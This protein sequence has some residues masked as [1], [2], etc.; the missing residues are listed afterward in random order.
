MKLKDKVN[1]YQKAYQ[2][3]NDYPAEALE[4]EMPGQVYF[5]ENNDILCLPRENGD[6]RYPLGQDGFNYWVYAS[7]YM[8]SNEGLFSQYLRASEGQ[9]PKIAF[10]AGFEK[11]GQ[12]E[13][14]PLLSVPV[15]LAKECVE[16][17]TIFTTK[18]AYYIT[19]TNGVRFA[20]RV[21]VDVARNT[22]W[23]LTAENLSHENKKFFVASYFNPFLKNAVMEGAENRWF[24]QA[25]VV[26]KKGEQN[27]DSFLIEVYEERDRGAMM[28]NYAVFTRHI[29]ASQGAE[30][31][32]IEE[33]T[34][35]NDY[36]GGTISSLHTPKALYKGTFGQT[37]KVTSFTEIGI[38][39]DI[40]HLA[41][42]P[43]SDIRI[44]TKMSCVLEEEQKD[45]A[46]SSSP[47]PQMIDALESALI[48]QDKARQEALKVKFGKRLKAEIKEEV[49]NA[50][51][52]H[53]KKQVEF[54]A[55]IKGYVQLSN[56]SLI[57]IRDVYQA[58]EGLIAWQ[59]ETARAKMLEGLN[60]IQPDGRAPRQYSL[61][62][63]EG[64]SPAMDLRAFIDQGVWIISTI[65]TYLKYTGDFDFL[66][67]MCGYYEF[68]DEKAHTAKKLDQKSS[69]LQH[70]FDIMNFLL[71][72]RD[73]GATGCIYALYGDW[74]DALDGLGVST[75][76]DKAFGTGVSIMATLQ[77]YQNCQEMIE[78]LEY[79]DKEY[80]QE[81]IEG[82]RSAR[83]QL[84]EGL[85]K[86]AVIQNEKGEK[87]IVHGWGDERSY[88]VGSFNDPDGKARDGITSN[89]FW[90]L[91]D[92]YSKDVSIKAAILDAY[93][94]L[95]SKY[96]LKTFCPHFEKGTHGVGR[97]PNLPKGT[98]ENG[99]VY[100]HASAFGIMSLFKMGESHSAWEE[101]AKALPF[102]HE[103]LSVSPYVVPN[104][105]GYNEEKKIDG[106]SMQDWQTG[107]SNVILKTFIKYIFGIQPEYAGIWIQ[108]SKDIPFESME[109]EMTLRGCRVIIKYTN[110]HREGRTFKVNDRCEECIYDT[111]M[112]QNKLWMP[113]DKLANLKTFEVE[114]MD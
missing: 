36:V 81:K 55:V 112:Q 104:S 33:T 38:A 35:R 5:I 98:A 74:N 47:S 1:T 70:M 97:I 75:N 45:T 68:V 24:R 50:F 12:Y 67:E 3:L 9:E 96:G 89:A 92:M 17:Y 61:P 52:E 4:K 101:L 114:V 93:R 28:P 27:L 42:K 111:Q 103:R 82:Y 46:I 100:I 22:Y 49:L 88:L 113:Y 56:F 109:V 8:H 34:S 57:G 106:E 11:D 87:K 105:Y 13:V 2:R 86:Y 37:K 78:L 53:L 76:K 64:A 25:S 65:S 40:F 108:P 83:Q 60:F 99:A 32:S 110:M 51:F 58:M 66:N 77:V 69:V 41:L 6:S 43:Y 23:S 30:I 20:V 10:F 16:R 14:V 71:K 31:I 91:S 107:S 21:F 95:D 84:E 63:F 39:G 94:R 18:S 59:P 62:A 72:N 26:P 7:G 19:E 85:L 44:D 29:E 54:C 48:A 79:L 90:V 73:T 102:T 15:I 80:Y